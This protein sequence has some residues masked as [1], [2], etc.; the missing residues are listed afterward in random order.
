MRSD[1]SLTILMMHYHGYIFVQV[2]FFLRDAYH[3]GEH[4]FA[5]LFFHA[6]FHIERSFFACVW[7]G[8]V[9]SVIWFFLFWFPV[10]EHF[11]VAFERFLVLPLLTTKESSPKLPV[12][13][14]VCISKFRPAARY[15]PKKNYVCVSKM[16]PVAKHNP[17]KN[18]NA[19]THKIFGALDLKW[20]HKVLTKSEA[21]CEQCLGYCE[22]LELNRQADVRDTHFRQNGA[23]PD[24]YQR[25]RGFFLGSVPAVLGFAESTVCTSDAC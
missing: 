19:E 21:K 8:F 23:P 10:T 11:L 3:Y 6:C 4:C 12:W 5:D 22:T 14:C 16:R 1:A 18:N 25:P 7:I 20:K 17:K 24:W 15:N 9:L 13:R 2:T